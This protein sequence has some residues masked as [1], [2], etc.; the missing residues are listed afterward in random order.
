MFAPLP[1]RLGLGSELG[2]LL[3]A[4]ATVEENGVVL[5]SLHLVRMIWRQALV[6]DR[7]G[8]LVEQLGLPLDPMSLSRRGVAR[9]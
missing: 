5:A 4:A 2:G 7:D 9:L 8:A 6:Q 3:A 1:D